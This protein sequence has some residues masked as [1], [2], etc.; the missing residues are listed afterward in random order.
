LISVNFDFQRKK[1]LKA[2]VNIGKRSVL[3]NRGNAFGRTLSIRRSL[4]KTAGK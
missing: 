1:N 3:W 2:S 4:S